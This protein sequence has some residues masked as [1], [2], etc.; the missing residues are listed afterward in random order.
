MTSTADENVQKFGWWEKE[1]QR[2]FIPIRKYRSRYLLLTN[3]SLKYYHQNPTESQGQNNPVTEILLSQINEQVMLTHARNEPEF[4]H[5]ELNDKIYRFRSNVEEAT[6]WRTLIM[7]NKMKSTQSKVH[8]GDL[9]TKEGSKDADSKGVEDWQLTFDSVKEDI[10]AMEYETF[11][12]IERVKFTANS[13]F[14]ALGA[15]SSKDRG[16][17]AKEVRF[18]KKSIL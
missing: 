14:E 15:V 12:S 13:F 2:G 6:L 16:N 4:L 3:S 5:I 7:A 10:L 8:F 17:I 18:K 11:S 1:I 9:P